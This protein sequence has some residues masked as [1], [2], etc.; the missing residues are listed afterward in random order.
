[1]AE[2]NIFRG[3]SYIASLVPFDNHIDN[4]PQIEIEKF[5]K[6]LES[7]MLIDMNYLHK[8][9]F[10]ITLT[11]AKKEPSKSIYLEKVKQFIIDL[12]KMVSPNKIR[13]IYAE[14]EPRRGIRKELDIPIPHYHLICFGLP[15]VP[16]IKVKKKWTYGISNIK[17][18]ESR[19]HALNCAKYLA[20]HSSL[21]TYGSIKNPEVRKYPAEMRDKLLQT[22][23]AADNSILKAVIYDP[24]K[25]TNQYLYYKTERKEFLSHD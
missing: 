8:T 10:L 14:G 17:V 3:T 25:P 1:M 24:Q 6:R 21:K 5:K 20:K 11:F 19:S 22:I 16:F 9:G 7:E 2:I 23:K 12:E 15:F 13:A 4:I 18:I